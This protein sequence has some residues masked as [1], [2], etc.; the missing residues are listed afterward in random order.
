MASRNRTLTLTGYEIN[1]FK[2]ALGQ[3]VLAAMRRQL[4]VHL[5]KL[6]QDFFRNT[7]S[8]LIVTALV[9]IAATDSQIRTATL[10]HQRRNLHRPVISNAT[11]ARSH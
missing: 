3:N 7:S 11:I 8:G 1:G 9:T 2:L 10:L 6:P 4:Y 5:L